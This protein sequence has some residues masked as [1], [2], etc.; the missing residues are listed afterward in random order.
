SKLQR[1]VR[2]ERSRV[3]YLAVTAVITSAGAP[4]VFDAD[5]GP[6]H[7]QASLAQ[8]LPSY[9]LLAKS[10]RSAQPLNQTI[11]GSS[12]DASLE[13]ATAVPLA[14]GALDMTLPEPGMTLSRQAADLTAPPA[15][16]VRE[17]DSYVL[18]DDVEITP[19]VRAKVAEIADAYKAKTGK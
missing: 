15:P 12:L 11:I 6:G 13:Q 1:L 19:D 4:H 10:T 17:T 7:M 14:A 2:R 18:A 5:A 8:V 9:S 16:E 3:G